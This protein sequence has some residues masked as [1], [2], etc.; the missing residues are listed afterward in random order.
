MHTP[1][2]DISSRRILFNSPPP[3]FIART[4]PEEPSVQAN[5]LPSSSLQT[6][7]TRNQPVQ[8]FHFN[9]AAQQFVSHP[10]IQPPGLSIHQAEVAIPQEESTNQPKGKNKTHK[11]TDDESEES[12]TV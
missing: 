1:V 9:P 11:V 2:I 3:N 10:I 6:D 8:S 4:K 7:Q 12:S 5:N